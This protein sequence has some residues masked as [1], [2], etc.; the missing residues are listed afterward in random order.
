MA[1]DIRVLA[2]GRWLRL[3]TKRGWEYAERHR[4]NTAVII[5]A[6]TPER[7]VL[8]VEQVR[9][10]FGGPVIEFPAGLVGDIDGQEN[11]DPALAAARELVEE[12]GWE[13]TT[14]TEVARGPVSPG[15]S[16]ETLIL[17]K[18]GGLRR[19]GPGG[20]D[21]LESIKVHEVPLDGVEGWLAQQARAGL[22]VDP[23]IYAG[24]YFLRG[25]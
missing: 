21:A 10:P 13:A 5:A 12:T 17:Y 24:L 7:N 3:V 1:E 23:K 8:F 19:V 14:L 22:L 2:E 11:E 9:I 16:I 4:G 25:A 18:A 20:G 15:I 6:L